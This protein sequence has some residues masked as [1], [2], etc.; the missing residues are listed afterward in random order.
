MLHLAPSVKC[1]ELSEQSLL[2]LLDVLVLVIL[3][4]KNCQNAV[5]HVRTKTGRS[6]LRVDPSVNPKLL[7]EHL[8]FK[9]GVLVDA[10]EVDCVD[11]I[12][13]DHQRARN[14]FLRLYL[15]P[16]CSLPVSFRC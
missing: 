12:A 6:V 15:H 14:Q 10:V 5:N 13:L 11:E 8:H 3:K 9:I 16:Y 1:D 4:L 7:F 2:F